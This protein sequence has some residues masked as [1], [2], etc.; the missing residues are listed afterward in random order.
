MSIHDRVARYAAARWGDL[1]ADEIDALYEQLHKKGQR[2]IYI[3]CNRAECSALANS[4]DQLFKRL[5]WPSIIG[6]GGILALGAIGIQVNPEDD[7]ARLLKS[8]IEARTKIKVDLSGI[9]RQAR[10][11]N[12]TMLVIGTKPT[13]YNVARKIPESE[14][15]KK[16][17][18]LIASPRDRGIAGGAL[19]TKMTA[20]ATEPVKTHVT[21]SMDELRKVN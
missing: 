7:T 6:E 19:L 16:L 10:D 8:A 1:S 20:H 12:P 3:S 13:D 14:A 11:L 17:V 2:S 4:F 9:P 15:R 5:G 21:R 18:A